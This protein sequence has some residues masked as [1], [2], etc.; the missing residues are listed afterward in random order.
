MPL[1]LVSWEIHLDAETP[2]H[3]AL[4]ARQMQ[5]DPDSLATEFQVRAET[6]TVDQNIDVADLGDTDDI[7]CL[8]TGEVLTRLYHDK[9][10]F[11]IRTSSHASPPVFG[12]T[13]TMGAALDVY[14]EHCRRFHG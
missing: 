4:L 3:A 7:V 14:R 11:M 12:A 9:N 13:V 2:E 5:L 10:R 1:Y 6:D 8:Q